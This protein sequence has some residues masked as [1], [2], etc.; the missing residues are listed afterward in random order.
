MFLMKR[1]LFKLL[2][3]QAREDLFRAGSFEKTWTI[4]RLTFFGTSIEGPLKNLQCFL[5]KPIMTTSI[6]LTSA[7]P[8]PIHSVT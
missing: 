1:P 5:H 3:E 2:P 6:Q 4:W 7:H 8:V